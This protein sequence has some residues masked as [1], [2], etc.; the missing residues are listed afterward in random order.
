MEVI[1]YF[2]AADKS[3]MVSSTV[4]GRAGDTGPGKMK[5]SR[6]ERTAPLSDIFTTGS[7]VSASGGVGASGD[8]KATSCVR[9]LSRI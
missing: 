9:L 8:L 5:V 2:L 6:L 7:G 3:S 1:S 4:L